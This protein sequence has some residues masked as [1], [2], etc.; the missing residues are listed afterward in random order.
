M[1]NKFLKRQTQQSQIKENVSPIVPAT[2]A[3]AAK[4]SKPYD[5]QEIIRGGSTLSDP[6]R[7]N[8]APAAP[9][10]NSSGIPSS[11]VQIATPYQPTKTQD[12]LYDERINDLLAGPRDTSEDERLLR[13]QMLRDVGSGQANLNARMAAGGMGTSGA[14][15]GLSTDMRARAAYEAAN[16]ISGVRQDARDEFARNT[17]A[18]IGLVNQ[19]RN[20]DVQEAKYQQY[21]DM[22]NEMFG[23]DKKAP[24]DQKTGKVDLSGSEVGDSWENEDGTITEVVETADGRKGTIIHPPA[25]T[26]NWLFDWF[27]SIGDG[28]EVK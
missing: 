14:L 2:N 25:S 15:S 7:T 20:L 26:G 4:P 27:A 1:Q 22:M 28:K 21:L 19:D 12:Q 16:A 5:V 8:P 17:Q 23:E 3:R 10:G 24:I 9:A 6:P 13:E 18:G 11:P